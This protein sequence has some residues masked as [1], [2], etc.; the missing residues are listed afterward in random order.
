M[1]GLGIAR[2]F[3]KPTD[4]DAFLQL[5]LLYSKWWNMDVETSGH[6]VTSRVH[7]GLGRRGW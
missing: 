4:L 2:Y 1:A 5:G 3:R 7:S 6:A